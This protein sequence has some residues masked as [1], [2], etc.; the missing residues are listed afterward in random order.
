MCDC[1]KIKSNLMVKVMFDRLH[2]AF[3]SVKQHSVFLLWT[4]GLARGRAPDDI[5]GSTHAAVSRKCRLRVLDVPL[6]RCVD[7]LNKEKSLRSQNENCYLAGSLNLVRMT[8]ASP[9][10]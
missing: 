1:G 6:L 10:V 3:F 8:A 9:H 4:G 5:D 2:N 7:K